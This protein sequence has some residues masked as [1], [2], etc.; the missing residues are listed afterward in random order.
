M[1]ARGLCCCVQAFP[2]VVAS[3]CCSLAAVH[4]VLLVLASLV[5]E[6]RLSSYGSQA[7]KHGFS[8]SSPWA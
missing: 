1:A 6:H 3:G 4:R 8:I 7:V 5:A 2:I